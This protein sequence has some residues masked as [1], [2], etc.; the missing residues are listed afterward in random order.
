MSDLL[1]KL[2][3]FLM[4]PLP[5][6]VTVKLM[7]MLILLACFLLNL[8]NFSIAMCWTFHEVHIVKPISDIASRMSC[9]EGNLARSS[10]ALGTQCSVI[11]QQ[12][13]SQY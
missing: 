8:L 12:L 9:I 2:S 13:E 11:G 4:L 3:G 6:N 5:L 10:E 7:Q 1:P